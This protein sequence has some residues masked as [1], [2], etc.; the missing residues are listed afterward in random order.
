[1]LHQPSRAGGDGVGPGS[2]RWDAAMPVLRLLAEHPATCDG[3][4]ELL[5]IPGGDEGPGWL[6]PDPPESPA[7]AG[8]SAVQALLASHPGTAEALEALLVT[9]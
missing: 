7:A 6:D 5:G 8:P 4:A 9:N 3:L 1:M 2:A